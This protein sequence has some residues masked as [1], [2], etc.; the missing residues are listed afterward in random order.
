MANP[1]TM[2]RLIDLS[3]QKMDAAGQYLAQLQQHCRLAEQ[4]LAI[5]QQYA[6]EYRARLGQ[7]QASGLDIAS[8]QEYLRFLK[9]LDHAVQ[10]QT[11]EVARHQRFCDMALGQWM[12]ARQ[13]VKGFETLES[14]Q[15]AE[16]HLQELKQLQKVMDEYASR[17]AAGPGKLA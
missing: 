4:K 16:Q 5:L 13:S 3:R 10:A 6:G 1:A 12:Q 17:A 9:Q 7:R 14:R 11:Q 8:M 2:R 15:L